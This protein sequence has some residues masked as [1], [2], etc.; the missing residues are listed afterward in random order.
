MSASQL[1][2]WASLAELLVRP[3]V[4]HRIRECHEGLDHAEPIGG[5]RGGASFSRPRVSSD[6]A[7]TELL[8]RTGAQRRDYSSKPFETIE[9]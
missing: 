8:F 2:R 1:M 6:N 5:T 3:L 7:Y 4:P 9:N